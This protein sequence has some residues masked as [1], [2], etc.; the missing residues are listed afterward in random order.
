MP[1]FSGIFTNFESLTTKYYEYSFIDTLLY[2]GFSLWFNME[3][4]HH[5]TSTLIS[6][7]SLTLNFQA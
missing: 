4:I 3:M 6:C 7:K 1:A 5:E 2:R